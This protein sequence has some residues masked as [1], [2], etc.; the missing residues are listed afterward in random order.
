[1]HLLTFCGLLHS[2]C[3]NCALFSE[4]IGS[5]AKAISSGETRPNSDVLLD[6]YIVIHLA[7]LRASLP[8]T[9][10]TIL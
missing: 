3:F 8:S 5:F 1:M 4:L 2:L 9:S 6:V 10:V 7:H